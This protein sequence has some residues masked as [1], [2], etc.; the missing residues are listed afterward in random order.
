MSSCH[1]FNKVLLTKVCH[2]NF[3]RK[4]Y[5]D[6]MNLFGRSSSRRRS[7]GTSS[8]DSSARWSYVEPSESSTRDAATETCL[9]PCDEYMMRVG[10]KEENMF[11]MPD[12]VP[13]FQISAN[14]ATSSLNHLSKDLNS[15][16]V[17]LGCLLCFMIIHLP[18]H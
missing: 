18:S 6:M 3:Y 9:W 15:T 13:T 1:Q 10:I 8:S 7:S 16:L 2:P 12:S 5:A 17:S 14:N 4:L 11:T